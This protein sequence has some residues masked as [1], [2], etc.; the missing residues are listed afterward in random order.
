[1][2]VAGGGRTYGHL[3]D[4]RTGRPAESDVLAAT[5]IAPGGA[6][7]DLLS[8]ALFVTGSERAREILEACPG[9]TPR[10]GPAAA[11]A[12]VDEDAARRAGASSNA[13]SRH[14]SGNSRRAALRARNSPGLAIGELEL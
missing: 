9:G 3:M 1:M 14:G 6:L 2:G 5:A 13:S 8:T 7:S 4:A 12:V 10:G 11:G